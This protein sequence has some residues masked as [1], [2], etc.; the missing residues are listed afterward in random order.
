MPLLQCRKLTSLKILV[1][2]LFLAIIGASV[3]IRFHTLRI[4]VPQSI[5]SQLI[6]QGWITTQD[7]VQNLIWFIHFLLV[8]VLCIAF[9]A[10]LARK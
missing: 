3:W 2:S 10:F 8:L 9:G 7:G 1:V 6:E 5:W 4:S